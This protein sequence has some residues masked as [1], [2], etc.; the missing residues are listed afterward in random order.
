MSIDVNPQLPILDYAQFVAGGKEREQFLKNLR[1]AA[2][3]I[4]FFYLKNHGIPQDLIEN[5]Q[6]LSKQFF[7]LPLAE[8]QKIH[9]SNSPH[10]RG[11]NNVHDEIT[12]ERPDSREQLDYMPEYE[13]IPLD[14]IPAD[15]PWLRLQGPN[16]WPESIPELRPAFVELQERQTE[17]AK[18]MLSAFSLAL[19]QEADALAHTYAHKPSVLSKAIHYPGVAGEQGVGAHKDSGYIT[20]VQQEDTAGLEVLKDDEW[21]LAAPIDG[22]FVVNIGELLEIASQG[23]LKATLHRVAPSPIGSNRFSLAY[24]LTSQLDANVP[25]FELPKELQSGIRGITQDPKNPMF[26]QIGKNFLKG[27][28]RSHTD[29]AK[30]FYADVVID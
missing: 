14:Q 19:G 10:F 28:L 30:R 29:V 21:V 20:F 5:V 15:E 17:L 4:G 13:A 22:T 23:Y 12:R 16:Q 6:A 26:T 18:S 24:F 9:M 8:K 27:R 11:Y 2:H 25:L 3:E 7:A 1:F